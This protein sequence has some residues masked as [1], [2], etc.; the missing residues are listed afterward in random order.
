MHLWENIFCAFCTFCA[1]LRHVS[2]L[3]QSFAFAQE[4][5]GAEQSDDQHEVHRHVPKIFGHAF[6][7]RCLPVNQIIQKWLC[8]GRR[9][10]LSASLSR[11][12]LQQIAVL[13][14]TV[15]LTV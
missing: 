10:I 7:I 1:S 5:L 12:A 13:R 11:D 9:V 15:E 14:G 8:F 4:P 2:W 3:S 6:G